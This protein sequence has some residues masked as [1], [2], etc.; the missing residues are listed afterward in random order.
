MNTENR[1]SFAALLPLL[2]LL[3][4]PAAAAQEGFVVTFDKTFDP[5]TIGPGSVTTLRFDIFNA[6][7]DPVT[8]L[9]FSDTLPAAVTLATPANGSTTCTDGVL[10]APDG[11]GTITL[12]DGR[13]AA[14]AGCQ[15]TV[16]VTSSTVG[17][18]TN[19]S[20]DLTSSAGSHG[21]AT[22]DLMV[23]ADR[24]GFSKSFA[25]SSVPLGQRSTLTFV[26][27][28]TANASLALLLNF[29]DNLPTGMEV[30]DPANAST[31]CS[32]GVLSAV[33][34]GSSVGYGFPGSATLAAGASC[35]V[36]VDVLATGIGTL[37][38][39]S[40]ELT[41]LTAGFVTI[42]SGKASAALDVSNST[43]TLVKAFTDD[44]VPV[45]GTVTLEF[46][47]TNFDRN[48]SATGI[49]FT[50]DLD[51]TLSGLAVTG[52]LPTDP[53][54][55]G[56]T[57]TGSSLLTL[58]GGT[59]PPEGVCTFSVTLLVP[60]ASAPGAF[61]NTTSSITATVDGSPVIGVPASELLFV[62]DAPVLSKSFTDDPAGA[63][64]TVT[65]EFTVTNP[66]PTSVATDI[67]FTDI[68]DI[69]LPTAATLPASP[70]CGAGSSTTFTPLFNPPM[71][72]TTPA[73]LVLTGGTLPAGGSCTFSIVLDILPGAAV[74]LYPNVTSAITAT[75]DDL[76]TT[77][78][79]AADDLAIVAGPSIL[80]SFTD[81]PVQPGATV[82]LE[83]TLSHD[84][85]ATADATGITFTDDLNAVI[86]GLAAT[87]LPAM[88][89]CGTGSMLTGTTSLT[90]TGGTLVPGGSC[91]FSVTLAVPAGA[92][93]GAHPNTTS[94]VMATVGGV[95]V[96]S[97][98]AADDLA[99]AGLTLSK[100]F[101][102]DP[103]LPGGMV[104]LEF[105]IANISGTEAASG[106]FFFDALSSS[107]TG[108]ASVSPTQ[109]DICGVGSSLTGT[110]TLVF[111]GGI[112]AAGTSCTFS[113]TLQ[114]P[115]GAASGIYGNTTGSLS[116][117]IGGSTIFFDPA[118]DPL[119]VNDSLLD[120]AKVFTDDP[121]QPGGSVN[122]E[123]TLTNLSATDAITG[124]TFTD[125]LD[126]A[127]S[128][129]VAVGLP[130]MNVCGMGSTMTGT[131]LLTLTAGTLAAGTS[132]TWNV[133]VAV[134]LSVPLGTVATN[135][136]SS[137]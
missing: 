52:A 23:V 123:F 102:D 87:G 10:T 60:A 47:V 90:L 83:F 88:D 59:L 110:T 29:T 135:T 97:L 72:S 74:G 8:L 112:L 122:L 129:L 3:W 44:P 43:V 68:F 113:A 100:S 101:T 12:A 125:D 95:A 48:F 94:N 26:I 45:G 4:V 127:L 61:P 28:N 15:V 136:T 13:L 21:T 79:P 89:V 120:L 1:T 82:T 34:G 108:L 67:S 62:S 93:S 104:T 121:A 124:I 41:S 105:T 70:P 42:S 30:A 7:P 57:L 27:D 85:L 84:A 5:D 22:D 2:A 17:T 76:T 128:G 132:C 31:T 131:G 55:V 64:G 35:T 58:T 117:S 78:A 134:P 65:L 11:G 50:D 16:D 92:T 38:N 51:A 63:G 115:A 114:V 69:I 77:G 46:T 111:T 81:D 126:A 9:A 40:E 19:L 99:I 80:K 54:G 6:T 66:S 96:T 18:H 109:N 130:A 116:A 25:P 20:G 73:Q 118:S 91:V 56:S 137:V 106:I 14:F 24:P 119:T 32:G 49:S 103:V 107:L 37:I 53:C 86:A 98:P 75:V 36:S 71:S 39:V 33:P 133:S